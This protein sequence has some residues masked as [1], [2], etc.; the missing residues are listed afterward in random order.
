AVK[1][2]LEINTNQ[3]PETAT[4]I[5]NRGPGLTKKSLPEKQRP[6]DLA[7]VSVEVT[8]SHTEEKSGNEFS[9]KAQPVS[10]IMKHDDGSPVILKQHVAP[11]NKFQVLTRLGL[12]R[13]PA[14]LYVRKESFKEPQVP[15]EFE[16]PEIISPK[17]FEYH[18]S[19]YF[20]AGLISRDLQPRTEDDLG[21]F[22]IRNESEETL[23]S[24]GGGLKL[25]VKH[26]TGLWVASGLDYIHLTERFSYY[27]QNKRLT[28]SDTSLT[29]LTRTVEKRIHNHLKLLSIPIEVGY[30][31][32][33]GNWDLSTGAGILF[34]LSLQ[35][36]GTIMGENP[37]FIQL[38]TE[39]GDIF[40]NRVGLAYTF[41]LG[42]NRSVSDQWSV[43]VTP[44]IIY[45]ANSFTQDTYNL[46]QNYW[47][48]TINAGV[49][50]KF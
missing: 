9:N 11:E 19:G 48:L 25:K 43:G 33:L 20:S 27:N 12:I 29:M 50:Y 41:G 31:L 44:R 30:D 46:E 23:E 39:E 14:L 32:E 47:L 8:L 22:M 38:G 10:A 2:I 13:P 3:E 15:A 7:T 16:I 4:Q 42:V 28:Y 40:K 24:L 45:F 35:S 1:E 6:V 17:N 21:L 49:R 36:E 18:L 5:V 37:E 34:N 26:K